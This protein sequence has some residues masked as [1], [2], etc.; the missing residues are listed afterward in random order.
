MLPL[1]RLLRLT[2]AVLVA[3]ALPLAARADPP[4]FRAASAD[5]L[6]ASLSSDTHAES[7]P[8]GFV[9]VRP[10]AFASPTIAI[11]PIHKYRC[12]RV[13]Y[14]YTPDIAHANGVVLRV[15]VHF[16]PDDQES[17]VKSTRLIA[18][19]L[20]LQSERFGREPSFPRAAPVADVW[21]TPLLPNDA[22]EG[23][24]T[25]DA[26]VY[27]FAA[28]G[29]K[30]PL[31]LVRTITH[32]WG[33]LTL[34][35]ARGYTEPE[36]DAGGYLGERLHLKW[37]YEEART[38][39]NLPDDGTRPEDLALY[40]R[41]QVAPL[42]ERWQDGGP[43]S[44]EMGGDDTRA[45][46]YYIGAALGIDEAYG[47]AI[48]GKALWQTDDDK[49]RDLLN[50]ME[51]AVASV[52]RKKAI[53]IKLPAWVPLAAH[54]RYSLSTTTGTGTIT[55][56]DRPPL[57]VTAKSATTLRV[58]LNGWKWVRS[59]SGDVSVLSLKQ[60]TESVATE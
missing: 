28:S 37:L 25:R 56:A 51:K 23:G 18:R 57:P 36:N 12:S 24:E 43:Q 32:E 19:L 34:P 30:T 1:P 20:H 3:C 48:L 31:E 21:F 29:I 60:Q 10:E 8:G 14:V 59:A 15:I 45:M 42:I 52:S 11:D 27:V 39:A 16:E 7:L 47:S 46:D 41:R 49:P 4:P 17:A 55:L 50:A 38:K 33:H 6:K 53:D 58:L 2:A 35:A 5:A 40:Y 9:V 26:N 54:A 44:K 13:A 22:K